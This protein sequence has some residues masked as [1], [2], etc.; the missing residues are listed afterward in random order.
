MSN[1]LFNRLEECLNDSTWTIYDY[2]KL[3]AVAQE[4]HAL[5][6]QCAKFVDWNHDSHDQGDLDLQESLTAAGYI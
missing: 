5:L 2:N 4:Q 3:A 6:I 1:T